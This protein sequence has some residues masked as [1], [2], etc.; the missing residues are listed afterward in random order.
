PCGGTSYKAPAA[1]FHWTHVYLPPPVLCFGISQPFPF[2]CLIDG[3]LPRDY[4]LHYQD[5]STGPKDQ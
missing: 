4:Q 1:H 3:F 2:K 5:T